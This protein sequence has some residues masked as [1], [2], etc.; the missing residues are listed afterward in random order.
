[1]GGFT[2][3]G[4]EKIVE[5]N[6]QSTDYV[7]LGVSGYNGAFDIDSLVVEGDTFIPDN[8]VK[9]RNMEYGPRADGMNYTYTK[10]IVPFRIYVGRKGMLEDGTEAPE[11]DFLARNGLKYGQMY[12]FAIDMRNTT[13]SVGPTAGVW[14]DA[15]HKTAQNGDMIPGKWIAQEWRWNGAGK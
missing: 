13:D 11:D 2:L 5:I 4:F 6:P 7:V 3:G 1:M 9:A 14:R 12:G 10:D 15:W 8:I